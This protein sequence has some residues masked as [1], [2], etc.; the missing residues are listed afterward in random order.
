ML[1]QYRTPRSTRVGSYLI[2]LFGLGQEGMA[3]EVRLVVPYARSVPASRI[4]RV[5]ASARPVPHIA[6]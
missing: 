1:C 6:P 4:T 2:L 5:A 3:Y